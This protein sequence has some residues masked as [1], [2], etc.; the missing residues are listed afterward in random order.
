MA[1]YLRPHSRSELSLCYINTLLLGQPNDHLAIAL[2][3]FH[4][5]GIWRLTAWHVFFLFFL[6]GVYNSCSYNLKYK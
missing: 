2:L 5:A 6:G 1:W 3:W 4:D